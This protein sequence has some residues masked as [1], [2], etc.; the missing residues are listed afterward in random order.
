[1]TESGPGLHPIGDVIAAV[2]EDG[3][4]D[5]PLLRP[6]GIEYIRRA[7]DEYLDKGPELLG[8]VDCVLTAAHMLEVEKSA[9]AAAVALVALVDRDLVIDALV[10]INNAR[11]AARAQ[12]VAERADKFKQFTAAPTERKAP[13]NESAEPD[14]ALKLDRFN[15]PKRL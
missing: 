1:M 8:A 15:F 13:S 10:E 2:L 3:P 7:L 9:E 6:E 14:G 4:D 12:A 11:E 5:C